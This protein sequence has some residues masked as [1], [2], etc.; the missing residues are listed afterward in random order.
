LDPLIAELFPTRDPWELA[1]TGNVTHL[2]GRYRLTVFERPRGAGWFSYCA[3]RWKKVRK[4][5]PQQYPSED[6]A[7]NEA[8]QDARSLAQS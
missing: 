5:S 4:I 7:K 2:L 3:A 6:E 8:E 1:R